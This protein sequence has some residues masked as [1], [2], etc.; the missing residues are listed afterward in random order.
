MKK[1]YLCTLYLIA[2]STK[3]TE[4]K[5][6]P[7]PSAVP[8]LIE[9]KDDFVNVDV[10][11]IQEKNKLQ[12]N[13]SE[14][15]YRGKPMPWAQKAR[16]LL[17]LQPYP[18]PGRI[19]LDDIDLVKYKCYHHEGDFICTGCYEGLDSGNLSVL[20]STKPRDPCL[21]LL[22]DQW[23]L[24]DVFNVPVQECPGSLW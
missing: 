6:V 10:L 7:V 5:E 8:S 17:Y 3:S 19:D 16:A 18:Y 21:I 11:S 4:S 20:C 9:K 14:I 12:D 22:T 13:R 1:F 23:S 15:F 2:C 24:E